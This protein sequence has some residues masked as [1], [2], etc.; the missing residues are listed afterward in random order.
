MRWEDY[1]RSENIEDRRGDDAGPGMGRMPIPLPI[2][3]GRLGLGGLIIVGIIALALGVD[4]RLL[5]GSTDEL[6]RQPRF[7]ERYRVPTSTPARKGAPQDQLGQFVAAVLAQTEDVWKKLFEQEGRRYQEPRLVLFSGATQSA[8]GFA[9]SAMGPFYCPPDRR[10]YLDLSFFRDLRDRFRAPGEFAQAYVIAHEIGH[11]V[12]NLLG[13]LPRVQE[14]RRTLPKAEG[15]R[16]SVRLEL[17]ADCFAGVWAHHADARFRIL[18][19]GDVEKALA[20]ANAVGDDRLQR[21]TQGTA[22]PDSFTHGT[23]AQRMSWFQNGLKSGSAARC[24]T[25][26]AGAVD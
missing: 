3:G 25:F 7:E 9:Q 26:A 24:N 4:P 16:L 22:V 12:Q 23:S 6:L 13:I 21:R 14:Q 20:A 10:V 17:Q 8:C 5:I 11:H 1:R 18:E 19:P 2:G 15:N